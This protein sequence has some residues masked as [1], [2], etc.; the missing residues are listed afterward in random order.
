MEQHAIPQPITSYEFRL[1]GDMTLK[2]FGK[3]AAGIILALIVYAI[4][5]PYLLKWFLIILFA[6]LGV[7]S[8]F[9]PFQGRPIDTWII[10]FFKRIYSPNQYIWK[11]KEK[12]ISP[13]PTTS[14]SQTTKLE[15]PSVVTPPHIQTSFKSTT[16]P[17]V[18]T[19][20]KNETQPQ[21]TIPFSSITVPKTP[22]PPEKTV[23]PN[24]S[25]NIV[26]PATPTMPN[27]IVGFV[28]DKQGKIIEGAILEIRD[29]QG[30]PVRAFKTNTLGQFLSATPL[31]NGTYEIET[32]KE[33]YEFDI[34]KINLEGKILPPIE[35]ISK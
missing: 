28:H 34:I 26:I 19:S 11:A 18:Q 16:P 33:G 9:V 20:L 7:I 5:P 12:T 14:S 1:V 25:S 22:P 27:L 10:A 29:S 32:E 2:Q 30:N 15:S 24:F 3:L 31:H 21:P 6:G 4:N 13:P 8:A 17:P 35:I 23:Q